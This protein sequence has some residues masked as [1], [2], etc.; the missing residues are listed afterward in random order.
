V[1]QHSALSTQHSAAQPLDGIRVVDMS[2]MWAGPYC[3]LQ[4]AHLGAE[5]IR[6]ESHHRPCMNRRVPPYPD[7]E[8]GLNRG[9]SFNQW[10]QG[11][12]SIALDLKRPEA[13]RLARELVAVSDVFVENYAAGV[14]DRLGL[15]YDAL[16]AVN[17]GLVMA[18]LSGY[19]LTGP[20]RDRVAFGTPLTMISGLGAL[21][22]YR[23]KGPS[24]I[25]LSYGDPNAGLHGAFAILAALW[26][27]EE[28]G[29][30]Q[31]IDV[32]QWEALIAILPDGILPVTMGRAQ[33]ERMGN[34][35]LWL[36]PHGIYRCGGNR[37]QGTGD[38]EQG[39]GDRTESGA[40]ANSPLSASGRGA[41]GVGSDRW[42]SIVIRDD[43]EWAR[44]A[45]LLGGPAADPRF[46]TREGRKR[47]ED[48]LDALISAWTAQ[49]DEWEVTELLQA[50][51]I[52]AAPAMDMRDVAEDPHMNAR[53]FFVRLDHPEVGRQ[54]HAGIPWKLSET[55]LAV[56]KAA[57]CLGEDNE[58]VFCDLLGR[59]RAEYERLVAEQVLY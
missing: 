51:G 39:T 21:T 41:G 25:G 16:S 58:Y 19:G 35:D 17:P 43:A 8:P 57:P 55:P 56:R 3:S 23:G 32:S 15:G 30:G 7:D 53:G 22:G 45:A 37:E 27:R 26:R 2:W 38:R 36:A 20:Y 14:V 40:E 42:V 10:N 34:R 33:P 31:Y 6:I 12:L 5:V 1:T 18:S 54:K 48:E 28:T 52:A 11:K 44:F 29:Q 47:H 49:R 13:V 46:G 50:T 4:L 59:S 24:E 9:G